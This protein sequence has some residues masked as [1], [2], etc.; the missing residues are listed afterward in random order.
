MQYNLD[1]NLSRIFD[2][3]YQNTLNTKAFQ[4][5]DTEDSQLLYVFLAGGG[6]SLLRQWL[7]SDIQKTP[8]EITEITFSII[9]KETVFKKCLL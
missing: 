6:C 2:F 3:L 9:N 5:L 8:K 1:A 4:F 7:M